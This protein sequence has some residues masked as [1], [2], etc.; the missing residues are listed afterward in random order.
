MI[1]NKLSLKK[2]LKR[3]RFILV[4]VLLF[5][6]QYVVSE[7]R[8]ATADAPGQQR[9][10]I[11][12]VITDSNGETI[13]G[14]N[15]MEKGT[16]NGAVTDIDGRF[17]LD[18]ASERSVLSVSYIGFVSQEITVGNRRSF[19]IL[20]AEDTQSLEEV[21]VVGYGSVRKSDITGAVATL[22]P[23]KL[24][25]R[26]VSNFGQALI[27]QMAGVQVQQITGRPDGEGLLVRVRG[28]ASITQSSDPL[29]VVD[30]FAMEGGAFRLITPSDI[31]SIQVLKDAS[32]TAIYGSRGSNGV[33]IIT[34]KKGKT[35][36]P[37]VSLTTQVGFHQ[38]ERKTQMMN[39]DQYVEWFMDGRNQAWLDQPII[40]AD[41]DKSPH[42]INDSNER[43]NRYASA[44]T[45]FMIPDG[46][47]RDYGYAYNFYDKASVASLPDTDWQDLL[48]RT[49]LTQQYEMSLTGGSENTKY[50]FS[51]A[52]MNEEGIVLGSDYE[53]FNF[54]TNINSQPTKFLEVGV[55]LSAYY[56]GGRE[57]ANGKDAPI[58]YALNLPPI[59]PERNEDGT[60]G[61][62]V[63][64]REIIAGD[65]ANPIAIAEHIYRYRT[66]EGWTG[67][68]YAELK[69]MPGLNYKFTAYGMSTGERYNRFLPSWIDLDGSRGP[70]SNEAQDE[71]R[72]IQQW[73]IE[74]QITYN[75]TFAQKHALSALLM[76][77]ASRRYGN[78]SNVEMRNLPTDNINFLRGGSRLE[79]INT[80][81][82]PDNSM[83]SY[84]ARVNYAFDN[85]Y[86][87]TA[88]IRRDGSSRFGKYNRWGN[89][90]SASVAWRIGQEGFMK[91]IEFLSDLKLRSSYG[92]AGNNRIGDFTAVG[93]L[94]VNQ[95]P[96]GGSIRTAILPTDRMY[97]EY[98]RWEKVAQW[99]IGLDAS[100]FNN[101]VRLEAEYYYSK[102]TDLLMDVQLPRITGYVNQMQ[103]AGVLENKGVEIVLNT[104]NM[105]GK[106]QWSTDFNISANRNKV[107]S[108]PDGRPRY[109]SSA[110]ASN[111]YITMEGKPVACF[112]GYIY[113]GVFMS[114][115]ELDSRPH[116]PVDRVGD[117]KYKD[118]NGD[119]KLDGLDKDIMGNNLPNFIGGLNNNFSYRNLS[120]NVQM[121]FSEGAQ[122]MS[123]WRRMCGIYHGDRNGLIEQTNRWRSPEQPG[124]GWHFRATRVPSGW[125][126]DVSSAWVED[127]SYI[128][129]RSVTL[130]YEVDSKIANRLHLSNLRIFLTGQNLYTWT[131]YTGF[132]PE[133]TSEVGEQGTGLARGGDYAGFPAPRSLVGG[134]MVS[135]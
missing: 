37:T 32:S 25:N 3:M 112:Y 36:R 67:S 116:Q 122:I 123:L 85:K 72:S 57:T 121:I 110:N 21:V 92:I 105:V 84:L 114:Q 77:S 5:S 40:S 87:L 55:N 82:D 97:N 52:Y 30:G 95:Y 8:I 17:S 43:R 46:N 49:A 33:I 79:Y 56:G 102:S 130:A 35:G 13:I 31:E 12:G 118:V 128:R 134:L 108:L 111:A 14:V 100:F 103:N 83:I 125:Q 129:I 1:I 19:P 117:G 126:R 22:D 88:S 104:K 10:R 27:G 106:F 65:V 16:T 60:W 53:R 34:T 81:S 44:S 54:R 124:D 109:Q 132:D 131:N 70:R 91:E 61:S 47:M 120:L 119:G 7:N 113:E 74:Q 59:Y 39:R 135:F 68:L 42:T 115:A 76:T 66:R 99:N 28:T 29:Y 71:R 78:R 20:L 63:R 93:T 38:R 101:R 89:F 69:L 6:T 11:T 2:L 9:V 75:K 64:N 24:R 133:T 45:N 73:D 98:L 18:V 86:L 4:A 26:P 15:V 90:P 96:I 127:A 58:Q 62:Q 107:L 48:F 41:P 23:E 51:G 94:D 50:A 80:Y